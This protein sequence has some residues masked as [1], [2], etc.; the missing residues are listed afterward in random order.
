MYLSE[1]SSVEKIK[2]FF[3]SKEK[4]KFTYEN[5]KG[6]TVT[7]VMRAEGI[8]V[9]C[10][11][12]SSHQNFLPWGVFWHAVH[13]MLVNGGSVFRGKAMKNK[14]GDPDLPF[15]SVEGHIAHVMYGKSR[16]DTVFR[17]ISPVAHILIASGVCVDQDNDMKLASLPE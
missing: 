17:R 16:G 12:D 4:G 11:N 6:N 2:L 9:D 3:K 15:D 13:I 10:L 14:L 7:C 8:E 5:N 1:S